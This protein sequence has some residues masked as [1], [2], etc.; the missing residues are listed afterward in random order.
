MDIRGARIPIPGFEPHWIL[1][2]GACQVPDGVQGGL[3][4]RARA[5]LPTG[6][7]VH[8]LD[9]ARV[10]IVPV[11][12]RMLE[13]SVEVRRAERAGYET[14]VGAEARIAAV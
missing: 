1:C 13:E 3:E 14:T 6:V 9:Y 11:D 4:C 10:P 12:I 5:E 7:V 2:P 8:P